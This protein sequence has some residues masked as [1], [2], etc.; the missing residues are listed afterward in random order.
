MFFH[1]QAD[2]YSLGV[3]G[4]MLGV[5]GRSQGVNDYLQG[6]DGESFAH[7]PESFSQ[8]HPRRKNGKAPN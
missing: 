5:K 4:D 3:N 7:V 1:V 8:K 2:S 6:A